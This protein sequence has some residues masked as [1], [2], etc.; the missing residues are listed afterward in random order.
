MEQ[1]ASHG[2]RSR[3]WNK[4]QALNK[5]QAMEQGAGFEPGASHGTR[6][7]LWNKEQAMEQGAGLGTRNRL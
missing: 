2:T 4:E 7:R 3:L 6:S 1:G 5:E